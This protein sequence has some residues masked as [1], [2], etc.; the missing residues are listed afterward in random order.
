MNVEIFRY[1]AVVVAS[2]G[3]LVFTVK[4]IY[5]M[6]N[7]VANVTGKYSGFFGAFLLFMPSQFNKEGNNHR[8][9]LGPSLLIVMAC[10][11]ILFLT[12]AIEN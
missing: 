7:A 8:T 12:G 10:W 5:H 2:I 3:A 6:Y 4:A 1:V 9:A 11:L